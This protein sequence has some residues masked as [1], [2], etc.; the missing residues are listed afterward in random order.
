[1]LSV[2]SNVTGQLMSHPGNRR[3]LALKKAAGYDAVCFGQMK[4]EAGN[5]KTET[6]WQQV[7][8]KA[9]GNKKTGCIRKLLGLLLWPITAAVQGIRKLLS[10]RFVRARK[11]FSAPPKPEVKAPLSANTCQRYI[12]LSRV[13]NDIDQAQPHEASICFDP[14][15]NYDGTTSKFLEETRYF[16]EGDRKVRHVRV[17]DNHDGRLFF[18]EKIAV[19]KEKGVYHIQTKVLGGHP[20]DP[21]NFN[22]KSVPED[23]SLC[24]VLMET[25]SREGDTEYIT[26]DM[27]NGLSKSIE[28]VYGETSNVTKEIEYAPDGS[29]KTYTVIKRQ[30][31]LDYHMEATHYQSGFSATEPSEAPPIEKTV[32]TY[33]RALAHPSPKIVGDIILEQ[34]VVTSYPDNA[35]SIVITTRSVTDGVRQ[36]RFKVTPEGKRL[37]CNDSKMQDL[38]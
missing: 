13:Y 6:F 7:N 36:K 33:S 15:M 3:I 5:A 38:I 28:N 10:S 25:F 12:S 8:R 1:M 32:S 24:K 31:P 14:P 37:E 9:F 27:S 20:I 21:M 30:S 35:R 23:S 34:T 22:R 26:Y 16:S 29:L 18:D 19:W 11:V 2:Q 17:S 4:T